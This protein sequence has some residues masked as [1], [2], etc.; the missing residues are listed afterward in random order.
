MQFIYDLQSIQYIN[1]IQSKSKSINFKFNNFPIN[2]TF[3]FVSD[4][5]FENYDFQAKILEG[6]ICKGFNLSLKLI[7]QNST[8][9]YIL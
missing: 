2:C 6:K 1:N 9:S 3:P 7:I 5:Q 4:F 8:K